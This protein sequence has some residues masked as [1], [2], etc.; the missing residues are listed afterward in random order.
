M[1]SDCAQPKG[2]RHFYVIFLFYTLTAYFASRYNKKWYVLIIFEMRPTFVKHFFCLLMLLSLLFTCSALAEEEDVIVAV[3]PLNVEFSFTLEGE[4]YAYVQ[5]TTKNDVGKKL[6]YS[7]NGQ[8]SGAMQLPNCYDVSSLTIDV[9]KLNGKRV[10]RYTGETMEVIVTDTPAVQQDESV[11]AAATARDVIITMVEGGFDYSFNVPGRTEVYLKAKSAQETHVIYL[12]AGEN[13]SYQG[14]VDLPLTFPYDNVTVSI[15]TTNS[16]HELFKETFISHYEPLP[17]VEQAAEGRLKGVIVCV[18]PGHQEETQ[19][20]TV[21]LAPNFKK[22][23]TTTV[24]MAKGTVTNRRESIVTLEVGLLLRNA[25]LKEGATVIMTREVQETFV[26]MLERADIPNNAGA[27]FVLRLHCNNRDDN[28][29]QGIA[30]YCPYQSSYAMEV[31]DEDTYREMGF[32]LLRAMQE[33]TG[34]TKGNCT[35]NNTYVGNNWSKMPSFLVEMGYM[36]NYKEDLLMSASPAYQQKLVDG[37]VEGI[38]ELSIM[39]G[40]IEAPAQ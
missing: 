1:P 31:A 24:G 36:S 20:E 9:M 22:T 6:L 19:V 4:E 32:T 33:A 27:D 5:V 30:I 7:E 13:Y 17:I 8:F 14:H 28:S 23:T 2:R 40:L 29:V 37:M 25:L 21:R 11:R 10:Y 35:L 39:R 38:Y 26:G 12:Q 18:D 15:L 34:Q 16:N 3:T